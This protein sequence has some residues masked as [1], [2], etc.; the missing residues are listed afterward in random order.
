[1]KAHLL[2]SALALA[3]ALPAQAGEWGGLFS[4]IAVTS[5]YRY[6]GVSN[7]DGHAAV[8]ANIHYWRPDGFYAG[9]FATGVDFNDVGTSYEIDTY[10]GKNFRLEAGRTALKL[11]GMYTAFPDNRTPGPTYDFFQA[12]LAAHRTTGRLTTG[13]VTSFV[14]EASYG[15]GTAWRAEA[16]AAYAVAPNLKVSGLVG[17]RWIERGQDRGYWSAGA[18]ATWKTVTFDLRYF[19]TNL[20]RAECGRFNP[21]VCGATVVG[22]LT[23]ALPP[24]L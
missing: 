12:K 1:M 19:D 8:Q 23:V 2:A 9:V 21:D 22:T 14:P 16:D 10:G 5:D 15:S 3:A 18:A 17:R 4:Q 6:Q 24:I 20:N 11:E 13:V 7:S